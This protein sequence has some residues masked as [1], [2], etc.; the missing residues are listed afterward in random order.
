MALKC[1]HSLVTK[2]DFPNELVEPAVSRVLA[3]WMVP[4]GPFLITAFDAMQL[5]QLKY[6]RGLYVKDEYI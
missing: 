6:L 2:L 1:T 3:F 4:G 5:P